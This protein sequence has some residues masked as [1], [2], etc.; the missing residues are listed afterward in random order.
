SVLL[1]E[2]PER[3]QQLALTHTLSLSEFR[4]SPGSRLVVHG[5]AT[6]ACDIGAEHLGRSIGRV[7]T[8]VSGEEKTF[9]LA[10]R[11]S[12]LVD[13]LERIGQAQQRSR[14]QVGQLLLQVEKTGSLPD[15]DVDLLKR[16]ELDQKQSTSRLAGPVD[17]IE[18]RA[19]GLMQ[20][21]RQNHLQD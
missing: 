8:I 6:D 19:T 16:V 9:E 1:Y 21:L 20:E 15:A 2:E 11:Q 18:S 12:A 7:L 5:E 10:A 4:L 14:D 17:S 3:P 13:E